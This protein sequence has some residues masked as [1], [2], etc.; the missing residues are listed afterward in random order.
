MFKGFRNIDTIKPLIHA[1]DEPDE[2]KEIGMDVG[3]INTTKISDLLGYETNVHNNIFFVTSGNKN[4]IDLSVNGVCICGYIYA[5]HGHMKCDL[6]YG[7]IGFIGGLIMGSYS[8][9]SGTAGL[10]FSEPYDY[11]DNYN[12]S[13]KKDIVKH[14]IGLAGDSGDSISLPFQYMQKVGYLGID[15]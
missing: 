13:N 11:N 14:L 6:T 5:P 10:V 1:Q 8:Y 9:Q 7:G 2:D 15:D 3:T 4:Y 12:L